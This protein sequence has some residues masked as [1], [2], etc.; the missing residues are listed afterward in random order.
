MTFNFRNWLVQSPHRTRSS[1]PSLFFPLVQRPTLV[2]H[3]HRGA[4]G[5]LACRWQR[6]SD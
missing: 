6:L 1:M 5:K 4:D 3:W 2:A